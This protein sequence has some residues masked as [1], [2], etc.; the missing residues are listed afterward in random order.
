MTVQVSQYLI[1]ASTFVLTLVCVLS[2]VVVGRLRGG[3]VGPPTAFL[4]RGTGVPW[5]SCLD[6]P[7]CPRVQ[8]DPEAKS[9]PF[10]LWLLVVLGV[11][12][13]CVLCA[14]VSRVLRDVLTTGCIS[15]ATENTYTPARLEALSKLSVVTILSHSYHFHREKHF[16]AGFGCCFQFV[17]LFEMFFTSFDEIS[18]KCSCLLSAVSQSRL[19][20][21]NV[22]LFL[23]SED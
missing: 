21:A 16:A 18:L 2:S 13:S 23:L 22:D 1:V 11:V 10:L 6:P 15:C 8:D 3:Y 17:I 20:H 14:R 7:V 19:V 9:Q 4:R 12:T 5:V